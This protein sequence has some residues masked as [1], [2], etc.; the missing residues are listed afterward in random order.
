MRSTIV[1]GVTG[2]FVAAS[3][4]AALQGCA[5]SRGSMESPVVAQARNL[6]DH[7]MV[8]A[9]GLAQKEEPRGGE[10]CRN[11]MVDPRNG[12]MLNLV[13]SKS[14]V[15]DY[16]VLGEQYE[17]NSAYG[18]DPRHLLRI[19]CATGKALGIVDQ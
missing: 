4:L 18:V 3:A 1:T 5:S 8:T 17:L 13:R 16:Q 19:D 10:G 7:F 14:G 9:S 2:F 6:P 12:T 11:P 15:G